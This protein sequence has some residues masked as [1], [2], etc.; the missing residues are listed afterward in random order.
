M[1]NEKDTAVLQ[2]QLQQGRASLQAAA[3]LGAN[4]QS[5]T[6]GPGVASMPATVQPHHATAQ[7]RRVFRNTSKPGYVPDGPQP[8]AYSQPTPVEQVQQAEGHP[9]LCCKVTF[10]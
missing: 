2:L 5:M 4:L 6:A 7:D 8:G 10:L 9:F 3:T 1:S